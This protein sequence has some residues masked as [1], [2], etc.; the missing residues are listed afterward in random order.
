MEKEKYCCFFDPLGDYSE[1]SLDEL[2]PHCHKPYGFPLLYPPQKIGGYEVERDLGRGFYGA[3]YIVKKGL[4]QKKYVL[5][6]S[7]KSFYDFA[8][9]K[10]APFSEESKL[11]LQA[12][13]G[14]RHIVGI[15]D[16]FEENIIFSDT[17]GSS[18]DCNV[19]VL[20]FVDGI[21][22]KEFVADPSRLSARTVAQIAIDLIRIRGEFESKQLHHND[23]HAGNL[24]VE[25]LA[26]G[27][28]RTDAIDDRI[29]LRA[30]DL[31]S[32][33]GGSKS[34]P[35]K[36]RSGDL[37]WIARHV[38]HMLSGLLQ[39]SGKLEDRE[40]RTALALQGVMNSLISQAANTRV[41]N[42]EDLVE[43][44]ANE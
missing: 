5:K 14:A 36:G 16:A 26:E 3:T 41:P 19:L 25:Q 29:I 32:V 24:L 34:D 17:E 30:I 6:I 15:E 7:P 28:R 35:S 12:S 40:I 9:F 13:E 31:G 20:D 44:I 1:K 42:S 8:P 37:E 2:C 38:D 4:F 23:L 18:L 21:T 39:Q 27:V 43:L 11:H 10:K 33:A 22:L